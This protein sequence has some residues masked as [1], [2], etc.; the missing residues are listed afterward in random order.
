MSTA[1][2][3]KRMKAKRNNADRKAELRQRLL[4]ELRGG[5]EGV[6]R[7]NART[8]DERS[9]VD[10]WDGLDL[11]RADLAGAD[12]GALD[13]RVIRL[14]EARLVK[15]WLLEATFERASFQK[16][17]LEQAWCAGANF[18][19]ADFRGASLVRA[20]LRG[21]DCRAANFH[22]ANLESVNLCGANLCGADLTLAHLGGAAFGDTPYD[23]RTRWPAGFRPPFGIEWAGAGPQPLEIDVFVRR[24]RGHVDSGRLER[25]LQMLR[26]ERFRLYSQVEAEA[27]VGVVRSQREPNKVYSCRIAADGSFGCCSQDLAPCLGMRTALCKHLMVLM[28]G[29]ARGG[30]VDPAALERW[31]L[32]S[33]HRGPSVDADL[34][35]ATLLRYKAAQAGQLD[36]RPT[37]TIPEDFYAL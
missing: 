23:E 24:L 32:A 10:G 26:E 15:A 19:G 13:L 28:V 14:D 5:P 1:T 36:W 18:E 4:Q 29:L 22:G 33:K 3:G 16:A 20:N 9:E 21:C 12:L 6:R 17:D 34:L 37:E 11:S 25:A 31:V 30:E 8:L 27:L 7:W 2:V 35:S